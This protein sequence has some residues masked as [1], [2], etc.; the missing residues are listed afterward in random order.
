MLTFGCSVS[1][2]LSTLDE[3]GR[4]RI[5]AFRRH[6]ASARLLLIVL[7]AMLRNESTR[8][9]SGGAGWGLERASRNRP[10]VLSSG[11]G[12]YTR[13]RLLVAPLL[14]KPGSSTRPEPGVEVADLRS[15]R[16]ARTESRS[17]S[18]CHRPSLRF[19]GKIVRRCPQVSFP[20]PSRIWESLFGL[21]PSSLTS[22]VD[23]SLRRLA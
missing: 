11:R 6:D 22:L 17:G 5:G 13:I 1:S 8:L 18:G 16:P 4:L 21:D 19:V 14:W 12:A 20:F 15:C 3:R 23:T 7:A 9:K 10:A 2:Q